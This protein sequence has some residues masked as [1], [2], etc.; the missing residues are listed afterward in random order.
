[1]IAWVKKYYQDIDLKRREIWK[2]EVLA[3][4]SEIDRISKDNLYDSN[5]DIRRPNITYL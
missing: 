5:H 4:K 3:H 2:Q 1:M